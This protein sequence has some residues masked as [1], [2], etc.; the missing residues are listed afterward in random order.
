M[1]EYFPLTFLRET[2]LFRNYMC[3]QHLMLIK[4]KPGW[5]EHNSNSL[6]TGTWFD[7]SKLKLLQIFSFYSYL[8][9][10]PDCNV[11]LYFNAERDV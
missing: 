2:V 5:Q 9:G 1:A 4:L 10:L 3:L 11:L 6:L 8:R 7:R